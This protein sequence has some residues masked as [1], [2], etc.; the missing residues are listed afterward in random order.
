MKKFT[1]KQFNIP[2][3]KGIS[4]KNIEE[5]LK[6]YA[7]YVNNCNT[8]IDSDSLEMKRRFGFEFDGMRNHEYFFSQFE[9]GSLDMTDKDELFI[10]IQNDLGDPAK[11]LEDFKNLCLTRGVGWGI[12]YYDLKTDQ[13]ISQ[14]VDEHHIGQLTGLK[15]ILGIDMWEHAFVYDY[16]TSE[17][18]KY[19]EAFFDN[20]NW[21]VINDNYIKKDEK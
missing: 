6:L 17:K 3:L 20:I 12:L 19:I 1:I 11:W 18:K 8:I 14:W 16:P 7:G 13:L 4:K 15:W 2:D 9:G 10:K 21:K 5:H